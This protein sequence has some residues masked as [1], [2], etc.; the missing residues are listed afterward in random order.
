MDDAIYG[1]SSGVADQLLRDRAPPVKDDIPDVHNNNTTLVLAYTAAGATARSGTT[2]GTGTATLY[3]L[4]AVSLNRVLTTQAIDITFYNMT[5]T[6]VIAAKY[7][8]LFR[9]GDVFL[10]DGTSPNVLTRI[11][12]KIKTSFTSVETTCTL[13]TLEGLNGELTA[14]QITFGEQA[15]VQ[16]R[17]KWIGT[18]GGLARAEY[19]QTTSLWE[20][21]QIDCSEDQGT[22]V[23]PVADYP[24]G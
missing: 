13:V 21:Y 6:A 10:Y 4:A 8:E 5:T 17:H 23:S 2:L 9:L 1:F 14:D 22:P 15:D 12:G 11:V 7:I 18:T 16:N 19:N 24:Y 3:Y 20:L